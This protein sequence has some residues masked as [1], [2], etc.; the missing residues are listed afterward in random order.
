MAQYGG[1]TIWF[2][3][4]NNYVDVAIYPVIASV[5]IIEHTLD[6]DADSRMI[7][8]MSLFGEVI[9]AG[10]AFTVPASF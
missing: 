2:K 10:N 5:F 1:V 6:V 9:K 4:S 3:D 8:G 7:P